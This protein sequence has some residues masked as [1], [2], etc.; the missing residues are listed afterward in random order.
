V[1][2]AFSVDQ[3]W[4]AA[5]GGIGTYVRELAPALEAA[6][7][8][9]ELVR[10]ASRWD[11]PTPGGAAGVVEVPATIRS[12]YPRWAFTGR[13][14]LPEP[15]GSCDVV[16]ATNHAAVP[17]AVGG[18]GLVVTVHDLAFERYPEMFPRT[19]LRLYRWGTK[20]A[21]DRADAILVPSERTRN[22]LVDDLLEVALAKAE[23]RRAVELGLAADVVV[24]PGLE[25]LAA[26]VVPGLLGNVAVLDEDLVRVPVLDLAGQPAASLE[27]QDPLPRR[28]QVPGEGAAAGAAADDDDVEV[29]VR[30]H[31]PPPAVV[32]AVA[33]SSSSHTIRAGISRGSRPR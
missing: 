14:A 23:H 31:P 7:P 6:D 10:F 22:D 24:D 11:A 18:Q 27:D 13:P 33:M 4:F 28:R 29:Q 8:S 16:H 25:A 5:P 20:A 1:R 17:P 2:V 12:L 19:W 32:A 26:L 21:I 15:L 3:L 30:A 9:L